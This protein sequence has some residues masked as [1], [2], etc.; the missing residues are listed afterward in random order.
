M[1]VLKPADFGIEHKL[2]GLPVEREVSAGT[3]PI[4]VRFLH[5]LDLDLSNRLA[6]PQGRGRLRR[7]EE[8][9]RRGLRQHDLG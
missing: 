7:F 2:L 8:D 4:E 6:Y 5:A 1:Q 9:L 3:G